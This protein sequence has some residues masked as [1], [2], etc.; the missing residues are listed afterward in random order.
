MFTILSSLIVIFIVSITI[1]YFLVWWYDYGY[2]TNNSNQMI[3]KP[4]HGTITTASKSDKYTIEVVLT[5]LR[6]V[7]ICFTQ[8]WIIFSMCVYFFIVWYVIMLVYYL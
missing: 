1:V 6:K 2:L 5:L 8:V 7:F 3:T 4:T